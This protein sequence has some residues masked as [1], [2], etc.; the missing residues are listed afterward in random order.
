M[1]YPRFRSPATI[2]AAAALTAAP[3]WAQQEQDRAGQRITQQRDTDYMSGRQ[4]DQQVGGSLQEQ[5]YLQQQQMQQPGSPRFQTVR[6]GQPPQAYEFEM[7]RIAVDY[8]ND[9][10]FDDYLFISERDLNQITASARRG[11]QADPWQQRQP[12]FQQDRWQQERWQQDQWYE[13]QQQSRVQQ[14]YWQQDQWYDPQQPQPRRQQQ[15]FEQDRWGQ[16]TQSDVYYRSQ[17]GMGTQGR[18]QTV[19]GQIESLNAV[20]FAGMPEEHVLARV[21]TDDGRIQNVDLGPRTNIETLALAA[22]DRVTLTGTQG[23]INQRPVLMATSIS[24]RGQTVNVHRSAFGGMMDT[25]QMQR[26][27]GRITRTWDTTFT[28]DDE[29][30]VLAVVSLDSGQTL[31]VDLGPEDLIDEFDIG[32]GDRISLIGTP[33]FIDGVQAVCARTIEHRGNS[34]EVGTPQN[35]TN[36]QTEYGDTQRRLQRSGRVD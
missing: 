22:G 26:V 30:H 19:R 32:R 20:R 33:V 14:D 5:Q 23:Q 17:P 24:S 12:R 31:L 11:T 3:A 36:I 35:I 9:G 34:F 1:T 2:L 18:Q 16:R 29:D 6:R 7:V 10:S 4:R 27:S 25:G 21:Q 28:H 15:G 13:P 8:N